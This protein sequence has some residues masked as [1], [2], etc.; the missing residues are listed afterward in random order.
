MTASGMPPVRIPFNRPYFSGR[1]F[2]YMR[3]ALEAGHISGDGDFSKECQRL[4][5][6]TLGVPKVLLTTSCTAALEMAALLCGVGPGDEFVLPSFTFVSTANA[7]FLR[8]ARPVFVDIREDTL[9][10]DE[11]L[12][13]EAAGERTKAIVPVHYAGIGCEMEP[14]LA[15]ARAVGASVVEDAAQGL[16]AAWHGRPLGT[17]GD[18]AAL[19]FHETKNVS[20]GEGGALILND[21]G[22]VERAEILREKGTNRS[23]FFRGQVDKYTWVDI[24]SSFLPSDLLA[25][26]LLAQLERLDEITGLRR[27]LYERYAQELAPLERGGRARLPVIPAHCQPNYH[28]Y[29]LLLDDVRTRDAL[30]AHLRAAGILAVFHYLPLHLSPVGRSLGY[31]D[32]QFPVTESVSGRLL[33]LPLYAGLTAE[34]QERVISTVLAFF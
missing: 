8:G 2:D 16:G 4:L 23:R 21:P 15:R 34:D 32:G 25:A 19:S 5:E 28:I 18:M 3:R 14:I 30:I 31:Q 24:G 1:E 13:A 17:A 10:M 7:F 6:R 9:N 11:H 29:Y 26:F 20:C 22:F 33:R 27:R 12:A